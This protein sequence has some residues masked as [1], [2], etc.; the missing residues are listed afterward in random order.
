VQRG[1]TIPNI[2]PILSGRK[3]AFRAN[4]ADAFIKR[5]NEF[6]LSK[7]E[8]E[9][10]VHL[11][12]YGPKG[13]G[14]L[15]R[16][17]KTYRLDVYRKLAS[18][19]DKA[20]VSAKKESPSVYTAIDLDKALD[21]VLLA[22]QRELSSME[23][24][25]AQLLELANGTQPLPQDDLLA[26]KTVEIDDDLTFVQLLSM[27]GLRKKE[28]QLYVHL[29]KYGPKRVGD[30]ARSMK[31][32]REDVYRRC[33]R[34]IDVGLATKIAEDST[35]YVPVEL[36]EALDAAFTAQEQEL[37]RLQG[38]RQRLIED[39]RSVFGHGTNNAHSFKVLKTVGEVVTAMSQL[40][41][42]ADTSIIFIAPPRFNL[43]SMGGF[44][45][46]L[47]YAVARGVRVRG[48]FDVESKNLS[49]AREFL[50]CGVE[51]RH[52]KEYRGVTMVVADGKRSVSLIY[53]DLKTAF[54]LDEKIAALQSV[55]VM[56]A[57]FLK[58]AF[59]MSWE[60]AAT[61][62]KRINQLLQLGSHDADTLSTTS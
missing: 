25:K 52:C 14:E 34:L 8:A 15:A 11:L 6:G 18:L 13:A 31:T 42:S 45:D 36:N 46:H 20:M 30:L 26:P 53:A 55:S 35:R 54:S 40:I 60:Q 2:L 48:V 16:S 3:G 58:S 57:E 49:A 23:E 62:E 29:L 24:I 37:R 33:A 43:I 1:G 7:T 27:F 47:R 10:Y 39:A 44:L 5:L 41:N 61:A 12:K 4:G 21:S 28:A 51:L 19:I 59:E 50:C 22:R 38:I 32:Y 17:L 56:Q 9:L